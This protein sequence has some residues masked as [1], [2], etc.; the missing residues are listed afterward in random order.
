MEI[1]EKGF[2][3]RTFGVYAYFEHKGFEFYADLCDTFDQGNECMI[4]LSS[5]KQVKTGRNYTASAE[6]R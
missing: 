4:F 1:I 2:N 6:S 5:N 3:P